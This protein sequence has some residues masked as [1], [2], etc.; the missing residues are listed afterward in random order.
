MKRMNMHEWCFAIVVLCFFV[1]LVTG[2][3]QAA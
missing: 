3:V 1:A 2:S